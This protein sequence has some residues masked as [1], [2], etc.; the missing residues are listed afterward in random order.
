MKRQTIQ[1][2]ERAALDGHQAG[3]S[4]RAYFAANVGT[5]T[6]LMRSDPA[7]WPTVADKLLALLV[8][9]DTGGMTPVGDDDQAHVVPVVQTISDTA[10]AAR[11]QPGVFA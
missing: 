5:I 11:L 10:T 9:G 1:Q 3:Q 8:S 2:L 4:W 6:P 7:G